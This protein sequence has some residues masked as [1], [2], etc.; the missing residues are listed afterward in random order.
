VAGSQPFDCGEV[1]RID[2]MI[3]GV[4]GDRDKFAFILGPVQRPY[5]AV[6]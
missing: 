5:L 1:I 4:N 2:L 6:E 3:P